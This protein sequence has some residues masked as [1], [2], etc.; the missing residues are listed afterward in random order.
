MSKFV[1]GKYIGVANGNGYDSVP[2]K[3][4][5]EVTL[6]EDRIE[7]VK[8]LS[9]GEIK[10]VGYGLKTSPVETI[11]GEIVKYQSLGVPNVI[12]AEKTSRD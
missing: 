1:P 7:D 10:G 2:S 4:K 6:S 3:I 8:I 5:V 11:P 9:H 12:G